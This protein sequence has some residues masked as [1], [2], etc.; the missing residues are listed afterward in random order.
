M[1]AVVQCL[2]AAACSV[3]DHFEIDYRVVEASGGET[4]GGETWVLDL[5]SDYQAP[6]LRQGAALYLAW[7]EGGCHERPALRPC[8]RRGAA[9]T[10]TVAIPKWALQF[11]TS[12]CVA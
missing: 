8:G 6:P 11:T 2:W 12:G 10:Y 4:S 7:N 1:R 3:D 9:D 5:P